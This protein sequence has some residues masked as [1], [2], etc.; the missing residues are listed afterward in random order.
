[1][2]MFSGKCDFYDSFI[3]T[4]GNGDEEKVVENLKKLNLF[5]QGED[6]RSHE[7]KSDTIKDITK[8]YPYLESVAIY[9]KDEGMRIILSYD[10]FIDQEE[11]ECL[12]WYIDDV[13]KY[14]RKCKRKKKPFNVEECLKENGLSWRNTELVKTIATRVAKDGKKAEFDDIHLPMHEHFRREWFEEMVRVGYTELQ[15]YNWCF[16]GLFDSPDVIRERLGRDL[17]E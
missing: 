2:S 14:W 7:V 15:A 10:S 1:M 3:A 4:H 8:Y 13:Y 16:K 6:G 17:N 9:N 12:N 11:R 5:V